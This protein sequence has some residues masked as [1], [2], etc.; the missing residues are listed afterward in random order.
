MFALTWSEEIFV[1]MQ[2][3]SSFPVPLKMTTIFLVKNNS[4]LVAIKP[5]SFE[6]DMNFPNYN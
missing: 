2:R 5:I 4:I 6:S 3:L 1:G